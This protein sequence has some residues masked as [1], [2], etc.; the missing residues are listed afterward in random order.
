[1]SNI[2]AYLVNK[3]RFHE[4]TS[5]KT[6][7]ANK[8]PFPRNVL[9]ERQKNRSAHSALGERNFDKK[10]KYGKILCKGPDF[11]GYCR[12]YVYFFFHLIQR[13]VG[14]PF[15]VSPFPFPPDGCYKLRH[16]RIVQR[17]HNSL[18]SVTFVSKIN[19]DFEL[20]I[21]STGTLKGTIFSA[22]KHLVL[23]AL[24]QPCTFS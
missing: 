1:M 22:M 16:V 12:F 5:I 21:I 14:E 13:F 24:L 8:A 10:E 2:K 9:N 17:K 4:T 11:P 23:K 15:E 18:T 3:S 7:G 20:K 19:N 6:C